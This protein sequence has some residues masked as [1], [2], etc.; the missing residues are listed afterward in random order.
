[1]A[2]APGHFRGALDLYP[3]QVIRRARVWPVCPEE[4]ACARV[5]SD[6]ARDDHSLGTLSVGVQ[7][8]QEFKFA[9]A[10][11]TEIATANSGTRY[12]VSR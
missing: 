7:N 2:A 6:A 1:M 10:T 9:I 12:R 4:N 5:C 3:C 11:G 8:L